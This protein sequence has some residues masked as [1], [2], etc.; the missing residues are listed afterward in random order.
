MSYNLNLF[1]KEFKKIRKNLN[2]TQNKIYELAN[3]N[4]VTIRRIEK[5]KVTP[6]LSTLECL[7]PIFKQDLVALFTKYRLDDYNAFNDI[8]NRIESKFDSNDLKTLYIELK[9]INNLVTSVN[10][11][12]FKNHMNQLRLLIESVILYKHE[13]DNDKALSKLIE[14]L[15]IST[16]S[17]NLNNYVSYV[18]SS[19]EVRILMNIA[20]VFNK[21]SHQDKYLEIL[22]FCI[23]SVDSNDKIYPK[24]CHNLG[25]AY[26]RTKDFEKALELS[27]K[28]IHA[29]QSNPTFNGLNILYYGKGIS[30][31]HLGKPNYIHSLKLSITLCEAFG[32]DDF[33]NK[34]IHNCREVFG[35]DL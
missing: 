24:L 30:E 34:I 29:C 32:Q 11:L 27:D 15:K 3:I 25:G 5:G 8:T 2:L 14:A 12:F 21:L 9:E 18:Y 26:R 10:N 17:F 22:Q 23:N 1:G 13:N 19:T 28:G 4:A 20:V 35:I 6:E 16:P 7:S 31:Y 33:K